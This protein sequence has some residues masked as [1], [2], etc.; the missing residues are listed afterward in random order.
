VLFFKPS[1]HLEDS[2]NNH[3]D[4]DEDKG[5]AQVY[6]FLQCITN[7]PLSAVLLPIFKLQVESLG[8]CLFESVGAEAMHKPL[9]VVFLLNLIFKG[10]I[11][12]NIVWAVVV[13]LKFG[14]F[15]KTLHVQ[16]SSKRAQDYHKSNQ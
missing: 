4:D 7:C 15:S 13:D 6:S 14:L 10:D 5:C 11:H 8:S 2:A 1:K 16:Y 12:W 9:L 3:V